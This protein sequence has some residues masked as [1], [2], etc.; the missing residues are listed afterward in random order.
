MRV[1]VS[2]L[3]CRLNR[4]QSDGMEALLLRAGHEV[5]DRVE[6]AEV[7]VLNGCTITHQ[8][9]ADA[10]REIRRAKERN[11]AVEVV[12][13]GCHAQAHAE[14]LAACAEV[15]LVLGNADKADV[16]RHLEAMR[17]GGPAPDVMVSSLRGPRAS[18]PAARPRRRQRALLEVQDGCNYRCAFCI[19][20]FVRGPSR[21]RPL[22]ELVSAVQ[23]LVAQGV[24]EIVLTGAHLGTWGRDLRPRRRVV[25]LVEE[26]VPHLGPVRLRLSSIDPHEVDD[27]LLDVMATHAPRV[28]RHLHL[29]VQSGDPDV[30]RRMRRGHS[31]EDFTR[32]VA[33]AR[34]KIEGVCIG[35][36]VIVGF[37]G[38][39]DAAFARTEALL[40][41]LP[42]SYH[43]V[44]TY[45]VRAG[46]AAASFGDRVPADVKRRRNAVLRDLSARQQAAF[47]RTFAGAELDAVIEPA[48]LARGGR[49]RAVT[50]NYLQVAFDGPPALVGRRIAVRLDA[51]AMRA[52]PIAEVT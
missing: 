9:D 25:D 29:P 17:A 49:L 7:F 13:T 26:L 20:P 3:G 37:P 18:L 2:T 11:G 42:L 5:V 48:R 41:S 33:R 34:A 8:A 6:D 22:S 21:S 16:V 28:C 4:A 50:D 44:F 14:A 10:R 30:L 40:S 43:H 52:G 51:D 31:V 32:L 1:L 46:T 35:T 47:R 36:D 19:V 39:D 45:S 24:A 15:D 23:G 38:E 27:A 12:V